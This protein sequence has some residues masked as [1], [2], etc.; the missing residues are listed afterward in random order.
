MVGL[1]PLLA[2]LIP[3][4]IKLA[5]EIGL[6]VVASELLS[7]AE[8]TFETAAEA[9]S[10]MTMAA[11][12]YVVE[13]DLENYLQAATARLTGE[14]LQ[15]FVANVEAAKRRLLDSS[16]QETQLAVLAYQKGLHRLWTQALEAEAAGSSIAAELKLSEAST[17]TSGG[18]TALVAALALGGVGLLIW[19]ALV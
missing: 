10:P 7:D 4:A 11:R 19:R 1:L 17:A 18:A 15:R 13:V 14:R 8:G 6:F 5:A 16:R 9:D 3:G 2:P 12:R